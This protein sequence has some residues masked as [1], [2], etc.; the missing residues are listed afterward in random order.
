MTEH[1]W[2]F[3]SLALALLAL[4][5]FYLRLEQ[6]KPAAKELALI[7]TLASLAA[8]GR[9]PF[10]A[11]PNVQPTTFLVLISGYVFGPAAGFAVGTLAALASDFFLGIGPWTPWQMI[12]WGAAGLTAGLWRLVQAKPHRITLTLF[13]AV[14]GYL[15]GA[16]M[17]IWHWLAFIYPLTAE[18]FLATFAA[19]LWFDTLHAVGNGA[20][21]WFMG[22]DFIKILS[23]YK[24]RLIVKNINIHREKEV[25]YVKKNTENSN[26]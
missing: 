16:I 9:V 12:A 10:A 2:Q 14:W 4:A 3:F 5:G 7:A 23:R 21:M 17:N 18:T 26:N 24:K 13:A 6:K 1:N 15:Y 25:G 11:I 8:L 20:F 22:L 19:A